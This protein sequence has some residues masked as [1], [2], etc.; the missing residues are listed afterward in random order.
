MLF[1]FPR[2]GIATA[3]GC[4]IAFAYLAFIVHPVSRASYAA[5]GL[6]VVEV[7]HFCVV[8]CVTTSCL[9][10]G[11]VAAYGAHVG[12]WCRVKVNPQLPVM[13][14]VYLDSFDQHCH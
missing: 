2:Y 14:D 10:D 9:L 12:S 11:R 13:T 8:W 1:L 6:V 5:F 3:F 7:M 4:R